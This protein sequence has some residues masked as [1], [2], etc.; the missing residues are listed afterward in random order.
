MADPNLW[1]VQQLTWHVMCGGMTL[2]R[3][4]PD[5]GVKPSKH[6]LEV[7]DIMSQ[8]ASQLQG[9]LQQCCQHMARPT[10][11][12]RSLKSQTFAAVVQFG[13]MMC[14]G[15]AHASWRPEQCGKPS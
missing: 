4:Q 13:L 10:S 9:L 12:S 7:L 8:V 14:R 2:T 5:Q 1:N 6:L 15:I 3:E 11:E